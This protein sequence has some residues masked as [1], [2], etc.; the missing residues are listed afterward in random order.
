[1]PKVATAN[2]A[3]PA[4]ATAAPALRSRTTK[5]RYNPSMKTTRATSS[6]T[7]RL[8]KVH[9]ASHPCRRSSPK[10]RAARSIGTARGLAWNSVRLAAWSAGK[11]R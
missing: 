11:R 8:R 4:A 2:Q 9:K 3:R 5:K 1:M 6:F 7:V 10:R